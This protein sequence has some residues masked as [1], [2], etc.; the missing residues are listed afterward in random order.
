[1]PE[2]PLLL[3]FGSQQANKTISFGE[4]LLSSFF[5]LIG[6]MLELLMSPASFLLLYGFWDQTHVAKF[7]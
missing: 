6:G 7:M 1:M 5:H 4:I 2:A 3:L